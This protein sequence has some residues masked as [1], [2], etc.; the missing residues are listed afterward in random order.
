MKIKDK[1]KCFFY[2]LFLDSGKKDKVYIWVK[3]PFL[4][5]AL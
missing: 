2:I 5:Y 1:K 3:T 4:D